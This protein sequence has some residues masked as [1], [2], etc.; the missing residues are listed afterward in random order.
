[1]GEPVKPVI[2]SNTGK[3]VVIVGAVL[4][5]RGLIGRNIKR[6]FDQ[7]HEEAIDVVSGDYRIIVLKPMP[8]QKYPCRWFVDRRDRFETKPDQGSAAHGEAAT[9]EQ[10][11]ADAVAWI[12]GH[13]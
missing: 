3:I 6:L 8:G 5:A 13:G 12:D 11:Y 7:T 9:V 1:M 10:A 4:L 2:K